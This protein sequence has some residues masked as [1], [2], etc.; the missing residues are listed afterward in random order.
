[1]NP[2]LKVRALAGVTFIACA[3]AAYTYQ[4]TPPA[5]RPLELA[6]AVP[7]MPAC[8]IGPAEQVVDGRQPGIGRTRS[9]GFLH[10]RPEA[11]QFYAGPPF[12]K[13]AFAGALVFDPIGPGRGGQKHQHENFPH[14]RS[15]PCNSPICQRR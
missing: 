15:I 11:P 6:L 8:H 2:T 14:E 12:G 13:K 10:H 9:F 1:M 5:E 4:A 3:F 7:V